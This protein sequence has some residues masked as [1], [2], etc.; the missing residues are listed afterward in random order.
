MAVIMAMEMVNPASTFHL[1]LHPRFR[2]PGVNYEVPVG[3]FNMT[4]Q[5]N[6]E[7]DYEKSIDSFILLNSKSKTMIT[8]LCE[9][10]IQCLSECNKQPFIL[11]LLCKVD[12]T[13]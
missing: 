3:F 6:H 13:K 2:Q 4:E 10:E 1:V 12:R 5:Q 8:L 9:R 7:L 11:C